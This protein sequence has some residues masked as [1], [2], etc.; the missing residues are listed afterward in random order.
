MEAAALSWRRLLFHGEHMR[1]DGREHHVMALREVDAAHEAA[2]RRAHA[3]RWT[4]VERRR[5]A[6]FLWWLIW[7]AWIP[8]SAPG[9]I[10]LIQARTPAPQLILSLTGALLFFA[11]YMRLTWLCARRLATG[12]PPLQLS[13]LARWAPIALMTTLSLALTLWNGLDWGGLFIYTATCSAGWLSTREATLAIAGLV[14]LV[15]IGVSVH[16]GLAAA[17]SPA[18]FV[19]IPGFVV[20]AGVR[21]MTISQEL[22]AAREEMA[23]NAAV[24]EE[25][26]RIARDLHDLLGHSLSLIALKSELAGRLA[27]QSPE[28]AASE[29]RD[30]EN[31][32]RTALAE[33]REA[34]ADYRQ[35]TLGSELAGARQ[36][37]AAAGIEYRYEGED[38]ARLELPTPVEAALAW[39]VREGV[40]NVI[41]HSRAHHCVI[42]L[43]RSAAAVTVEIED[44]GVGAGAEDAAGTS[45]SGLRGLA[46]RVAALGGRYEAGPQ[47][48]GGF[49]LAVHA[50]LSS[51]AE[52]PALPSA[53]AATFEE[54]PS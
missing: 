52:R 11:L 30:I 24:A 43:T 48:G 38:D 6:T 28:R 42:R 12:T 16:A 41:R 20:I 5:G 19:A 8:V 25:R 34:I 49:R 4:R 21:S 32:A 22:R 37:L 51:G 7:I 26:L 47:A 46:Q 2:I 29:I 33:V 40:T 18:A 27:L 17:I 53:P 1:Y 13:P 36:L 35:S 10:T 45:G 50:P 54:S 14:V 15:I 23:A 31:A 44:D 3:P 9:I 39:T